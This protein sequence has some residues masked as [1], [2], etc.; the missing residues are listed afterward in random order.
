MPLISLIISNL[1]SSNLTWIVSSSIVMMSDSETFSLVSFIDGLYLIE[2][3]RILRPGGYWVLSGPPINW[4]E[5]YKGWETEPEVLEREQNILE[6]LAKRL[7]WKKVAEGEGFG[8]WQK[9]T[10]HIQ[11]IQLKKTLR[12]PEFCNTS[13]ADA[14]W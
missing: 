9:P 12:Y 13:D 5:N 6:D 8:V 2:I 7:C 3:D 10:N 14:G 4:R 11:C 1:F